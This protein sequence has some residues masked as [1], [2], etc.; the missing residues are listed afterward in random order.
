MQQASQGK[1]L[2]WLKKPL[3]ASAGEPF[4]YHSCSAAPISLPSISLPSQSPQWWW[5]LQQHD[6]TTKVVE[7]VELASL[8]SFI[9]E[10]CVS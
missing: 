9:G 2:F 8:D 4:S 7:S 5:Q 6:S 10:W 3:F 1:G